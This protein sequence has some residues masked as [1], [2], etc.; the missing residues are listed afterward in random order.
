MCLMYQDTKAL[1]S[2]YNSVIGHRTNVGATS[3]SYTRGSGFSSF[4][5]D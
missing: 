4:I 3:A 5:I 1:A 2:C